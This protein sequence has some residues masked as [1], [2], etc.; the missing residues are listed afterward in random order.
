MGVTII[1]QPAIYQLPTTYFTYP[2]LLGVAFRLH[3]RLGEPMR[4]ADHDPS[5]CPNPIMPPAKGD[6]PASH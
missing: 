3:P 4:R 2:K 1:S 5:R 6:Q